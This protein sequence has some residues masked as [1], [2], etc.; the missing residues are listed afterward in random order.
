VAT[1]RQVIASHDERFDPSAG[2]ARPKMLHHELLL[3]V[4]GPDEARI[5]RCLADTDAIGLLG[6]LAA[7]HG[8]GGGALL[9][10]AAALLN[11]LHDALD[12][13]YTVRIDDQADW[14]PSP[15]RS[16]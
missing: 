11:H 7:A 3:S 14:V 10:A 1:I 13:P 4:A 2:S 8:L 15:D 9:D 5:W 12:D 16:S 6:A